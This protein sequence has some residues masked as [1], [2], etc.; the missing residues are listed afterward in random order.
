MVNISWLFDK[1]P[2]EAGLRQ[3]H[4]FWKNFSQSGTRT[5]ER[6]DC[7]TWGEAGED[8]EM[9]PQTVLPIQLVKALK[10]AGSHFLSPNTS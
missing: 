10:L 7:C 1:I 4:F 8:R 2:R 9:S 3:L 6:A 5:S